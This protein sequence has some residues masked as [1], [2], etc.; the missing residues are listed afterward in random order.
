MQTPESPRVSSQ[1]RA[2]TEVSTPPVLAVDHVQKRFGGLVAIQDV[3]FGV[4]PREI[5]GVIGPNGAGKTTLFNIITGVYTPDRGDVHLQGVSV[6]GWR[7]SRIAH[8]G[9][10]RTFQNIR[11]FRELSVLD[12]VLVAGFGQRTESG[13][14]PRQAPARSSLFGTL[15][16]TPHCVEQESH[17]H[18]RARALLDKLGLADIAELPAGSVPYGIQRKVEIARALMLQPSVL[19]LDE[20]AA[21]MSSF[22]THALQEQI[23]SIRDTF[24]IAVV[25]VEHNMHVVMGICDRVVCI[26]RGTTIASGSAQEVQNH[27]AVLA[28]Y[29]GEEKTTTP[30]MTLAMT[31]AMKSAPVT[32]T[33]SPQPTRPHAPIEAV[34]AHAGPHAP[35]VTTGLEV[36]GL[37]VHYGGIQALH[38]VSLHASAGDVVGLMGANG[39]GKT[40]FLKALAGITPSRGRVR[41]FGQDITPLEAHE[42]VRCGMSLVP[43]GRALF[44]NL[45]VLENLE[46]GAT[47]RSKHEFAE[48][49]EHVV[50]LFP[51]VGER[52]KQ[53]S[54]TL[55][56]GEQQMVA[57]GRALMARPR[58]LLLDEPSL[59][60]APKVIHEVF[61]A[62][63]RIAAE[64]VT[65]LLVEQNTRLCL[66]V[67]KH[68]YVLVSGNIALQGPSAA[69]AHDPRIQQAYLGEVTAD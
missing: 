22:E 39:A 43:E 41:M 32:T 58:L 25:L 30:T 68:A 38:S 60:L 64:G 2:H 44:T 50:S 13:E 3:S 52:L 31:P 5:V 35:I 63:E 14:H 48:N 9:I 28:A 8:A 56:G 51:R 10:A 18:E 7:P 46:L 33:L 20:P 40:S 49:L 34:E 42:R 67:S 17:L 69:L 57:I 26:D 37:S 55:S 19:L 12:N 47:T 16:Q 62:I 15:F 54:G 29:L 21:G 36:E 65:L 4:Q 59:G 1:G 66:Q 6:R 53:V 45:T 23:T 61:Q 11:V 24:G 27:P